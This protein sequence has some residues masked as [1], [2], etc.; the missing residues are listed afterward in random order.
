MANEPEQPSKSSRKREAARLQQVG[1]RLTELHPDR[2]A[3]LDLPDELAHAIT[4]HQRF[5]SREAKRRQLQFIGRLMRVTDVDA[6]VE[7]LDALEGAAARSKH[8]HHLL[9]Q[10]RDRLLADPDTV[11]EF[12]D[13]HPETDRQQLRQLLKKIR[14]SQDE[15]QS[16]LLQRELFRFIRDLHDQA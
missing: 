3:T 9:E 2:L 10:W 5:P 15:R 4:E 13:A 14:G 16:K 11:T 12:I 1:L 6:I 7:Q 8:N